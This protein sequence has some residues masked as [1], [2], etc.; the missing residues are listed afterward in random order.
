M[1]WEH[2]QNENGL[3]MLSSEVGTVC[4]R[5]A[6]TGL[7]GG[8]AGNRCPYRDQQAT[9]WYVLST[10]KSCPRGAPSGG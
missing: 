7:C 10:F 9:T 5:S 8:Q 4:V 2:V 1:S 6:S 3:G